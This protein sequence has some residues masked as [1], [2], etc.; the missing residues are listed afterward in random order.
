MELLLRKLSAHALVLYRHL[1]TSHP[2]ILPTK[3]HLGIYPRNK[4]L[5]SP[6]LS[7]TDWLVVFGSQ[8][9]KQT[10][11]HL[12]IEIFQE[13]KSQNQWYSILFIGILCISGLHWNFRK[14]GYT[15]WQIGWSWEE[16]ASFRWD[17]HW[18]VCHSAHHFLPWSWWQLLIII[19]YVLPFFIEW[20]SF[21]SCTYWRG[22]C[23][24]G[25]LRSFL[26]LLLFQSLIPSP[27]A[28]S[29]QVYL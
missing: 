15:V 9:A 18:P 28:W 20:H 1:P 12:K 11:Q 19:T 3:I 29:I 22:E 8:N 21:V 5:A 26:Y 27:A 24:W 4:K 16:A 10:N 13:E 17:V 7:L 23:R 25:T 2:L 14:S 6:R